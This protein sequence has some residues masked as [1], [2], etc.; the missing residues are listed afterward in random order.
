MPGRPFETDDLTDA[1]GGSAHRGGRVPLGVLIL[2]GAVTAVFLYGIYL[3]TSVS[4]LDDALGSQAAGSASPARAGQVLPHGPGEDASAHAGEEAVAR[5]YRGDE[6][7]PLEDP[8]ASQKP[9]IPESSTRGGV[10]R[11]HGSAPDAASTPPAS[12]A[13]AK[14]HGIGP[15]EVSRPPS[16]PSHEGSPRAGSRLTTALESGSPKASPGRA[17]DAGAQ[18]VSAEGRSSA[19]RP[20]PGGATRAAPRGSAPALTLETA[21]TQFAAKNYAAAAR[22]WNEWAQRVPDDSWTVQIAAVRLDRA[23]PLGALG[24]GR[25]GLFVLPPGKLPNGLSPV[26]LGIYPSAEAARRALASVSPL[27]GST[28]RPIVKPIRSLRTSS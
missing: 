4:G 22:S 15:P 18:L 21:R 9:L 28:G 1:P 25:E 2:M 11:T 24:A 7:M 5:I 12:A 8:S 23:A 10:D 26:C 13:A 6:P 14:P 20:S 19:A 17:R 27:A 16:A 3:K